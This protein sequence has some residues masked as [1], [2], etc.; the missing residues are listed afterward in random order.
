MSSPH[1]F[2]RATS[3]FCRR[4]TEL[5][6][7]DS[8]ALLA[9]GTAHLLA[10]SVYN[11]KA[12]RYH[13]YCSST[14]PNHPNLQS[15]CRSRCLWCFRPGPARSR[16]ALSGPFTS[17]PTRSTLTHRNTGTR[18]RPSCQGAV[19]TCATSKFPF[20]F[21]RTR[22]VHDGRTV[23]RCGEPAS[24]AP[25]VMPPKTVTDNAGH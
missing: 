16:E 12:D 20:V 21:R 5:P 11:R 17:P 9:R 22:S 24:V 7:P 13:L 18:L 4:S 15:C 10:E 6:R 1:V 2:R 19:P 25:Q 8:L 14:P 23:L 3:T